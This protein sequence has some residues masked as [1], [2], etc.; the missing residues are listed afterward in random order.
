MHQQQTP[1]S[2]CA[3]PQA[4]AGGLAADPEDGGTGG[5]TWARFFH[6][7]EGSLL[8][9]DAKVVAFADRKPRARAHVLVVP[10]HDHIVGVEHLT[11]PVLLRLMVE[12]GVRCVRETLG[13]EGLEVMVGFHRWPFRSVEHLHLH[14]MARPFTS[15]T[16]VFKYRPWL[17]FFGYVDARALLAR[18]ERKAR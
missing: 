10:R 2:E 15:C 16:G 5:E 4:E 17:P 9:C 11:D 3:V 1:Q 13:D 18:L 8:H 7:A 14:A 6:R 12:V